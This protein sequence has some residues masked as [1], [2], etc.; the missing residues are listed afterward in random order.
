MFIIFRNVVCT[1]NIFYCTYYSTIRVSV[2]IMILY[3]GT[4][5]VL[6][7]VV[8]SFFVFISSFY[9]KGENIQSKNLATG[10]E[11]SYLDNSKT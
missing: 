2:V 8:N 5:T 7:P 11:S 6:V 9:K 10:F 1:S 3:T 4:V